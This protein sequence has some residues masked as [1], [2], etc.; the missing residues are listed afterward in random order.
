M[1]AVHKRKR[2]MIMHEQPHYQLIVSVAPA[3]SEWPGLRQRLLEAAEW[4]KQEEQLMELL[5]EEWF[6]NIVH[7]AFVDLPSEYAMVRVEMKWTKPPQR[8]LEL[9]FRD[10]GK[11]FDPLQHPLPDLAL[12][13]EER[14]QGGLGIYFI[15]LKSKACH[16]SRKNG[17]NCFAIRLF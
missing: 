7:H 17:W 3:L 11:A 2:G 10:N 16:Y 14:K 12:G 1:V 15:R 4:T 8:K 9:S 13:M 6:V 5:A